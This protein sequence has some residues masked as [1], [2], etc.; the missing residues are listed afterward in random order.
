MSSS[1]IIILRA[2]AATDIGLIR[3]TNEDNFFLNGN[4]AS[5]THTSK[6]IVLD[7]NEADSFFMFAVSDGMGG[8]VHGEKASFSA[9]KDLKKVYNSMKNSQESLRD[10]IEILNSYIKDSNNLIYNM[11]VN[12]GARIGAT[13][14]ALCISNGR[15]LALN[16]GDS[17]VYHFRGNSLVQLTQDHT[18]AE[19]LIRLGFLSREEAENSPNTHLLSRY[20]GIAP[21]EGIV[22]AD[23]SQ[24]I[25][26]QKDDIFLLCSDGLTNMVTQERIMNIIDK[27]NVPAKISQD[28]IN[29][30]L[31]N[32]GLDNITCIVVKIED[33]V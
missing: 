21:E 28:L 11:S 32:G 1:N 15:A 8:E 26:L 6:R 24:D 7:I 3:S 20:L 29:E 4:Y 12:L 31:N 33:I 18:E 10:Y 25:L 23:A 5:S 9:M 13:F 16:L 27:G 2:C 17:R 14:T 19:R 30:S 22:E